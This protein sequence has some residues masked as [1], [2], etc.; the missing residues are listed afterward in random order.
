M[1]MNTSA[2]HDLLDQLQQKELQ[3]VAIR[4]IVSP[5]I[6]PDPPTGM[7]GQ[8]SAE[9]VTSIT[10]R[11]PSSLA[12]QIR[13]SAGSTFGVTINSF[14]VDAVR[15]KLAMEQQRKST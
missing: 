7:A 1:N 10:T 9:G 15:E 4:E 5:P 12:A 13:F 11:F 6:Y 14:V 3:L 2:P 8:P